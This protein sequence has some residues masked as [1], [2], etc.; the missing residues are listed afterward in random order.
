MPKLLVTRTLILF[1]RIEMGCSFYL[2]PITGGILSLEL[3]TVV[4]FGQTGKMRERKTVL[5]S[6]WAWNGSR[7][8]PNRIPFFLLTLMLKI[9]IREV[10]LK[11]SQWH[12]RGIG[13]WYRKII[14][15]WGFEL[16]DFVQNFP[17]LR[18]IRDVFQRNREHIVS[19]WQLY[20][21]R[22]GNS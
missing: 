4:A 9:Q 22:Q 10:L 5:G 11:L 15:I 7:R 3:H 21:F 14:P 8:Y 6:C 18:H 12:K 17:I 20:L 16:I 2:N 13:L 1:F 19:F